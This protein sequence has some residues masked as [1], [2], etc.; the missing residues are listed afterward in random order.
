MTVIAEGGA[1]STTF[2]LAT[3]GVASSIAASIIGSYAGVSKS[4]SLTVNAVALST[5]SVNPDTVVGGGTATGSVSLNGQAPPGGAL[6]LL[7]SSD[8]AAATV[9]NT[10]LMAAGTSSAS[11]H[12]T[13]KR[14]RAT[15][16]TT[17]SA[18]YAGATRSAKLKVRSASLV[19][20]ANPYQRIRGF[21][22]D[23]IP[24]ER[25]HNRQRLLAGM[26]MLATVRNPIVRANASTASTSRKPI[27]GAR[28]FNSASNRA[29]LSLVGRPP[30]LNGP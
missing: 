6:I 14:L 7:A 20:L 4:A 27:L 28:A 29:L 3:Q 22:R 5:L 21:S 15:R 11:F 30:T 25:R 10:V 9:P 12:I 18:I 8:N 2:P 26:A 16:S 23:P 24:T 19:P 17:I 1:S 13:S